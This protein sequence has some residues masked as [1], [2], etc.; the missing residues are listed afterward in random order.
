MISLEINERVFLALKQ[1]FPKPENSARRA[2]DKY[3]RV[4]EQQINDA[5]L[6]GREPINLKLGIVTISLYKQRNGGGQIGSAKLRLQNWLENNKLELFKVLDLGTNYNKQLTTI[7]LSKLVT[8]KETAITAQVPAQSAV[9][10]NNPN[11]NSHNSHTEPTA[12][13]L[14]NKALFEQLF[15]E[16]ETLSEAE[17]K[18]QFDI[19]E[20]NHQSLQHYYSWLNTGATL[21]NAQQK[22]K[23]ANQA[24]HI[25]RL[26][27]HADGYYFQRRKPSKYGRIYYEGVSVQN[28]NKEMRRAML[29]P[30]WEHDVRSSVF[31]WKMCYAKDCIRIM[32]TDERV[33]QL[34]SSTI[35]FLTDKRDFMASVRYMTFLPE[36]NVPRDL[37]DKLIKRA[38]TAIGF[39][40]RSTG[41]GKMLK[42][43]AWVD[44][45]LGQIIKNK[46]E[47]KRFLTCPIIKSFI[48][49]QKMLDA[50]IFYSDKHGDAKAFF[51][52]ADVHTQ[53]GRLSKAKVIAFMY[54][55]YETELMN[56]VQLWM[57][58]LGKTVIA[59][60]HDAIITREKL[61]VD[62][63]WVIMDKMREATGNKYWHLNSKELLPYTAPEPIAEPENA[64]TRAKRERWLTVAVGKLFGKS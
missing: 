13:Q 6:M 20:V 27:A 3:R 22:Q 63:R 11:A 41:S 38:I 23:Y 9:L 24:E 48:R 43:G 61:S 15:P 16:L 55:T 39:G 37:Q 29:A 64:A 34:F 59:R 46:D 56:E 52:G 57:E 58:E 14:S 42:D 47:L 50:V 19:V 54:Q 62:D 44:T 25:L 17:I 53:S 36:S 40:A 21:L 30:C 35:T 26:S 4:L 1:Q 18:A 45:T 49:E 12:A 33:E 60:I 32:G 5:V 7:K 31:T 8:I 10:S 28:I 2:L 51:N